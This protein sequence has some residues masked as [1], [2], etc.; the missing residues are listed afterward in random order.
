MSKK[1][2]KD[3]R[4]SSQ[5]ILAAGEFFVDPHP[6]N[7]NLIKLCLVL[8]RI[9]LLSEDSYMTLSWTDF[10]SWFLILCSILAE[11]KLILV[12]VEPEPASGFSSNAFEVS[13]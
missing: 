2:C 9:L 7:H 11:V 3:I 1:S 10:I 8:L 5:D 4:T 12:V 6:N 13:I